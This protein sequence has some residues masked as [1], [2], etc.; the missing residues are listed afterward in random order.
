MAD[1]GAA[2][3]PDT[4]ASDTGAMDSGA[5]GSCALFDASSMDDAAVAAGFESV[6]KV[7]RCYSCHQRASQLV[8]DAG[9]GIVLS[10]NNDGLGDSGTTYPPNLTNDPTGLGCWTNQ[11]IQDAILDGKDNEGGALC[12]MPKFGSALTLPNSATPRPGT[13]M[14]A[15]TADEIIAYLRSLPAVHNSVPATT[16]PSPADAGSGDQ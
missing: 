9:N 3:P 6:W 13:P 10:G 7:Y 11:Q 2:L 12:V 8:D 14:D 16:C 15:G 1:T 4:G 5:A